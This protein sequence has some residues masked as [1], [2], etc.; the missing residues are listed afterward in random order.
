M[1]RSTAFAALM[2][3]SITAFAAEDAKF[4]PDLLKAKA[5]SESIC[6][7]CHAADG[8]STTPANPILAGQGAEYLFKQL[9]DYKPLDGKPALRSNPTM[10]GMTATL[11]TDDMKSLAVFFSQQ[12]IKP[13]TASNEKLVEAGK[14]LWRKG[15][16]ERGIPACA[17]CH[18]PAG[19]GI[20]AQ[21][22]RLA[23]QHADY[24]AAQLKN[25]RS[26]DRS[27][28]PQ[29]MMRMIADKLSDKQIK[30]LA[31]Y[32]AGLR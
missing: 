19:A 14:V 25:F 2:A 3:T 16:F 31:D 22:P 10:A 24:T 26:E 20:P 4:T 13:A 28:D 17:G 7:A 6:V 12:K 5:I 1:I 15:D 11:T 27:N 9:K 23:G 21:F 8:N 29:G 30:A 18:G 32:I